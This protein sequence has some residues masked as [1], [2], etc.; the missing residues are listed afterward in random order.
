[1]TPDLTKEVLDLQQGGHLCQQ[2]N[3]N[4]N[5]GS[6]AATVE[7]V[8][9]LHRARAA[10]KQREELIEK[11]AALAKAEWARKKIETILRLLDLAG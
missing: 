4:G 8:A 2:D 3:G 7:T 6:S 5:G 11:R 10:E 9:R 1:M